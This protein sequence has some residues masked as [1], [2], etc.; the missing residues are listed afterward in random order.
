MASGQDDGVRM[1]LADHVRP[2]FG[3]IADLKVA[4]EDL[5]A[6]DLDPAIDENPPAGWE[7]PPPPR[8][9]VVVVVEAPQR[10]SQRL[11]GVGGLNRE[12]RT[13]RLRLAARL[14]VGERTVADHA[15]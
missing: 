6:V 12:R 10:P 4:A 8:G 11:Q 2:G 3:Q 7:T 1:R 15:G 13:D 14:K 5:R 9:T